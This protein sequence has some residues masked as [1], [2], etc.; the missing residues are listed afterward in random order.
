M[1]LETHEY[2]K[3][4]LKETIAE[5]DAAKKRLQNL[6]LTMQLSSSVDLCH[7][8]GELTPPGC[9]GALLIDGS[10]CCLNDDERRL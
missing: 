10:A 4:E 1:F 6:E 8:C 2:I 9:K 3:Q 5:L 7:N